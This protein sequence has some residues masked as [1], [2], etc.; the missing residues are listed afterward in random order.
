MPNRVAVSGKELIQ[1]SQFKTTSLNVG[2]RKKRQGHFYK[3]S[4]AARGQVLVLATMVIVVLVGMVALATDL[5][6]LWSERRQMQS[7]TDAAAIAA[8]SA[9]RSSGNVTSAARNVASLNGFTN[10]A[11]STTVTVNNPPA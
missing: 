10:G 8:V 6:I 11:N 7:A 1:M 4:G 9:L 2:H 3:L 5:G